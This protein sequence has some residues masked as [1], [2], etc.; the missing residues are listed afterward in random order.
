MARYILRRLI[1]MFVLLV[2]VSG[3][4]FVIFNVFPSTDPAVLRAGRQPTPELIERIRSDLGL[5]RPLHVQFAGYLADVFGHLDF[6][7]SYQTNEDVLDMIF[8]DLPATISIVIGGVIVWVTAGV[9]IGI[10][11]ALKHR[12]VFDRLAIGLSLVAISAPVYWL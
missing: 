6:G 8:N 10:L 5:D 4:T 11:S 7:R 1:G 12:S 3:V 2:I 9:S